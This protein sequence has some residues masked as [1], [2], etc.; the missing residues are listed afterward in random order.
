MLKPYVYK[1]LE[2]HGNTVISKKTLKKYGE[3]NI[4]T[5]LKKYGFNVKIEITEHDGEDSFE[6]RKY[7]HYIIK[8]A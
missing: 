2:E 8:E 4:I 3:H 5:H 1:N 7:K 6:D